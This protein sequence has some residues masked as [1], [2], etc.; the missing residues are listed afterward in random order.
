MLR[1]DTIKKCTKLF[2]FYFQTVTL[3]FVYAFLTWKAIKGLRYPSDKFLQEQDNILL[4]FKKNLIVPTH[5]N[6][7]PLRPG[8]LVAGE[9]LELVKLFLDLR[10]EEVV[11]DLDPP[12]G[13]GGA[14]GRPGVEV[15]VVVALGKAKHEMRMQRGQFIERPL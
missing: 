2:F 15:G 12:V 10:P 14:V 9:G 5:V 11:A 1:K 13:G 7:D 6:L 3:L 4:C 8:P